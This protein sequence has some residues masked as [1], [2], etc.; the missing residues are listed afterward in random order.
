MTSM[1]FVDGL[2]KQFGHLCAVDDISL[3]VSRGEALGFLGPNGSGKSTTM[4]MIAGYLRP[5]EGQV[6]ICGTDMRTH[7][8]S[9]QRHIGFLPEGAPTYTDISTS[10]YLGFIANIRQ[11]RGVERKGRIDY[12]VDRTGISEVLH[13]PIGTLS[14]GYKRR[15]GLAQALLHDPDVLILDEPTDGLDPNQKHE[16]RDLIREISRHKAIIIST[17]ILDEVET[18]CDRA[19][20]INKGNIVASG[21]VDELERQSRYYNAVSLVLPQSG[22]PE[23]RQWLQSLPDVQSVEENRNDENTAEL[24]ALA[25]DNADILVDIAPMVHQQEWSVDQVRRKEGHLNELFRSV[26]T[27]DDTERPAV[28][29]RP[30][31]GISPP[32][33]VAVPS[34]GQFNAIRAICKNELIHYFSTPVAYV[35]IA[36]FLV[37][38][39]AFTFF[40]GGFF[41]RGQASLDGFFQFHPWLYLFLI[42]AIAMRLWA[43]ERKSGTIEMLLTLPVTILGAALGKLVAAWLVLGLALLL[44][45]PLWF[46]VN[47]LGSPDNAAIAAGY[48]GSFAMAGG[49][50]AISAF[51]SALTRNQVIAF[52][53]AV[54]ICLLF[55]A[56]GLGLVLEFFSG[57]A[58]PMVLDAVPNFS[59]LEHFQSISRG[60]VDLGDA[61][62]FIS[63]IVVFVFANVVAVNRW[64]DG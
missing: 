8:V 38:M 16:V 51:A 42:P 59:F 63:T 56:S 55:T 32:D 52:V 6:Q 17:H 62:F 18:I 36:I 34:C 11:M 20:I 10:A 39:G 3:T 7:P 50:L 13:Q 2:R 25:D 30:E 35:F 57:W 22:A 33:R 53:I 31:T 37:A 27:T 5:D 58:P 9:A 28:R 43:E 48:A 45:A 26:T 44:T 61:M 46:S 64:K 4:K 24:V 21:T 1:V 19:L 49:Y 14:K 60:V 29:P 54:A 40:A 12:V 23:A 15:V 41:T 47:Y